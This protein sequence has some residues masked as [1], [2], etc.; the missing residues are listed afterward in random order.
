MKRRNF[1]KTA[2]KTEVTKQAQEQKQN[3][4]RPTVHRPIR[5]VYVNLPALWPSGYDV[6]GATDD[7]DLQWL[8]VTGSPRTDIDDALPRLRARARDLFVSSS[9]VSACLETR[10]A[11]A[12]GAGLRLDA[13]PDAA[14]L[15]MEPDEAD[16]ADRRI[17]AAWE[18]WSETAGAD[19]Q[20]LAALT[21]AA[22]LACFMSGDVFADV[23]IEGRQM[24]IALIE[25]DRV[26]TPIVFDTDER[27]IHGVRVGASGRPIAYYVADA[28]QAYNT[29]QIVDYVRVRAF[30]G[31]YYDTRRAVWVDPVGGILHLHMPFE[32]P[33]QRRGI[34]AASRVL[35]DAKIEDRYKTAEVA[36]AD[37]AANAALLITHPREDAVAEVD[38]LD[39]FGQ[40][41]GEGAEAAQDD[42]PVEHPGYTLRPG[43][44]FHLE[45]GADVRSFAT[46]RPNTA[47]AQFCDAFDARICAAMGLPAEVVQRRYDSSY[48]AS[49]AARL[50]ADTTYRLDRARIVSQFL[51][52]IYNAWLDLN[53]DRLG[54]RGYYADAAARYAW[55]RADFI[56]EAVPSIDPEKE[57]RA[58]IA[59]IGA[60]L[61]TRAREARLLNGMDTETIFRVLASEQAALKAAGLTP[62]ASAQDMGVNDDDEATNDPA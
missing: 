43:S 59:A 41:A 30:G 5:N 9:L 55:R 35:I 50:D 1:V 51:R 27:V 54:L 32:R 57:V 11:G 58:A 24:R 16:A 28:A 44:V 22:A 52:P 56:G 31:G 47:F 18:R 14:I 19:G 26:E 23:R 36:A 25:G 49:R 10:T 8:C 38:M 6:H 60:G 21:Q 4:P 46:N 17:E 7:R 15:G 37:V 62:D 40:P 33:G 61:S 3:A 13:Q 48:S 42:R 2:Q 45:P 39:S 53:A 34:P 29:A 12:V 20:S